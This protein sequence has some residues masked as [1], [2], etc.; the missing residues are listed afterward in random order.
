MSKLKETQEKEIRE[1]W[2]KDHVAALTFHGDLMVLDWRKPD[3]CIF[4]VRY[5]FDG[6]HMYVSGDLGQAVFHFTEIAYYER[7][8][9]YSLDYFEEK[10]CAFSRDR[11]DFDREEALKE[12]EDRLKDMA[13][14][15]SEPYD[16]DAVYNL[17]GIINNCATSREY[18]ERLHD[19]DIYRFYGE[20]YEWIPELGSEISM[21]IQAYLIGLQMANEQLSKVEVKV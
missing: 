18:H 19:M 8:C 14:D 9:R 3:T 15:G 2:F 12:L 11:R 21:T 13:E 4:A 6:Y 1:N 17:R 10:L 5:V 7:I 16:A 20:P